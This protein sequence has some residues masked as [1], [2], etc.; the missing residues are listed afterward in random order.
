MIRRA[1]ENV[2]GSSFAV[3]RIDNHSTLCY[4]VYT[5]DPIP[6]YKETSIMK[7]LAILLLCAIA[8]ISLASCDT[9]MGSANDT[10]SESYTEAHTEE[11]TE[12]IA[13]E[14]DCD[15]TETVSEREEEMSTE[16]EIDSVTETEP[17]T[18][19]EADECEKHKFIDS[20]KG[21]TYKTY[22]K[23]CNKVVDEKDISGAN[24]FIGAMYIARYDNLYFNDGQKFITE[25]NERTGRY[26]SFAHLTHL[27]TDES[28]TT[29]AEGWI[30]VFANYNV[31][32]SIIENSG[33]YLVMRMRTTN[34]SRLI[35]EARA[36]SDTAVSIE[37]TYPL[38]I[39]WENMIIDMSQFSSYK[40]NADNASFWI[41]FRYFKSGAASPAHIMDISYAAIVDDLEKAA[42]LIGEGDINL[43]TDFAGEP[44]KYTV[45]SDACTS[46]DPLGHRPSS[47][48]CDESSYCI[49]CGATLRE[50]TGHFYTE[51]NV[52]KRFLA[53]RATTDTP[54]RYYRSC[55]CGAIGSEMFESG[56]TLSEV[57]DLSKSERYDAIASGIEN[58]ERF[59]YFTDTHYISSGSN[60]VLSAGYDQ[61]I[62]IMGV[63]FKSSD[64]S[65]AISGGD[66]L[67]NSNTT[68]G[69]LDC[70]RDI[71][72]RM[73][74]AFGRNYYMVVGNHDYNYQIKPEGGG[75]VVMSKYQ[76]TPDQIASVWYTDERYSGKTYYSFVG[77]NTKVYVFD[78]G[79]D[80]G[81]TTTM[82]E[83]DEEQLAWFLSELEKNDDAHIAVAPHMYNVINETDVHIM[84]KQALDISNAY[85]ERGTYEYNRRTYDF[86]GK[87]G[88][89]EFLIAGHQHH[90]YVDY[91]KGI[92]CVLVV[93]NGSSGSYPAFDMVAVDYDA[94]VLHTVRVGTYDV[95]E[96]SKLDRAVSLDES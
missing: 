13:T 84:I 52:D 10:E 73:Q 29:N 87:S 83:Y 36:D 90:D 42:E 32:S 86:S 11:D 3:G 33:R 91:Y 48:K 7:K 8:A 47:I 19:T 61:H 49:V 35:L 9:D 14:S 51:M 56:K 25:L 66:W 77:E 55:A 72:M 79:I 41:R 82:N 88:R 46:G 71:D 63:Y 2:L 75:S 1:A 50:A 67:N 62:D 74:T 20:V 64:L 6:A 39:G 93:N 70:M 28:N 76:L 37:R 5:V 59:M 27:C 95:S 15:F 31:S 96:A 65:F 85:N 21:N 94:R 40:I 38:N 30:G 69:A 16:P 4:N 53:S 45:N 57:I 26:E 18:E 68:E 12:A 60:G 80:W 54:A 34:G 44:I 81:H 23:V 17:E 78:C 22:C 58:G 92:P 43:Y 24:K 89:V